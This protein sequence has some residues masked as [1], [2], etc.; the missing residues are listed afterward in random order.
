MVGVRVAVTVRVEVKV[1]VRVDARLSVWVKVRVS[2]RVNSLFIL[3]PRNINDLNKMCDSV[4][5]WLIYSA[6]SLGH[7]HHGLISHSVTLS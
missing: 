4:C 6:A 5:G 1:R 2:V 7:Q 3:R